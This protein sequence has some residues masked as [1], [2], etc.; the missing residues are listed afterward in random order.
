MD[1]YV[2]P[3]N[4]TKRESQ[5]RIMLDSNKFLYRFCR[6]YRTYEAVFYTDTATFHRS[7]Y[8]YIGTFLEKAILSYHEI[9]EKCTKPSIKEAFKNCPN[10]SKWFKDTLK[11]KSTGT[12]IQ[13]QLNSD[14]HH[15]CIKTDYYTFVLGGKKA[16]Y[17]NLCQKAEIIR[18]ELKLIDKS[19]LKTKT[20]LWEKIKKAFL[21]NIKYVVRGGIIIAAACV[22][23]NLDLPDFDF[24]V[25]TPDVDFN[26]GDDLSLDSYNMD[27]D[28][29]SDVTEENLIVSSSENPIYINDDFNQEQLQETVDN[30]PNENIHKSM[31]GPSF[32]SKKTPPN[33]SRDGYIYD[34]SID[35][36]NHKVYRKNGKFWIWV[37]NNWI[38]ITKNIL[39]S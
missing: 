29:C 10:I 8:I 17:M 23:T 3:W 24:D 12:I 38:D 34:A 18:N 26:F 35:Y 37:N 25:E 30:N 39:K 6:K 7:M 33:S 21:K 22:G 31:F 5:Q 28:V 16:A 4:S 1:Y 2:A 19:A 32:G 36:R 9:N 11:D 13:L 27:T 15:Y 14:C 20:S